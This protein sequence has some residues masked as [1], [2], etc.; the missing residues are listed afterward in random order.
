MYELPEDFSVK[1][2][3]P[4]QTNQIE[5][6]RVLLETSL[7]RFQILCVHSLCFKELKTIISYFK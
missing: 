7:S 5:F 2:R 3:K 4:D 1:L 6:Y